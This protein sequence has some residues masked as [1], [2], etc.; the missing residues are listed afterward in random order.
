MSNTKIYFSEIFNVPHSDLEEYGAF[1]I[2]LV[3]DTPAFIDPFLIFANPEFEEWHKAII[4]YLLF[5]KEFSIRNGETELNA[6]IYKHY[7]KFWEVKQIWLW[8]SVA[9]NNG[10]WLGIKFA[11]SLH[12][13]LNRLFSNFWGEQITKSAHLEK[14]CLIDDGVGVDKLSDFT[15]NIIKSFLIDYT[16][17]FSQE[18]IS[19]EFLKEFRI[20]K[21]RFNYSSWIWEDTK[22]ILPYIKIKG[23]DQFVLLTPK[24]ILS[25]N[26]VTWISKNDFLERD[27]TIINSI[28]NEE[29]RSKVNIYFEQ[30]LLQ[31][32]TKTWVEKDYSQ[33][34]RSIALL[35]T[36]YEFPQILDYYIRY[37]ENNSQEALV[38]NQEVV[39]EMQ[40][41]NQDVEVMK[42]S[43]GEF[44]TTS[45]VM[46]DDCLSRIHFFKQKMES[47]SNVLFQ[48]GKN[49]KEKQM[50]L[51]FKMS[52][53][54][55][56]FDYNSEV[57][58]GR[59]PIDFLISYGSGEKMGIE[60]KLASNSK[61]KS[62]LL[63]QSDVYSEDSNLKLVVKV[64]FCFSDDEI[65]KI[66]EVLK[67][68]WVT[69]D[70]YN[71]FIID[72]RKK[73]SASNV[74][75]A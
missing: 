71:Y 50:Q 57:N 75:T 66:K 24:N 3:C 70:N 5:L 59:W 64:I 10:Q 67:S 68:I 20:T 45:L 60:F 25:K 11:K 9:S 33:R 54:G 31:K 47:N 42:S 23:K 58:N 37:K 21:W 44:T 26:A 1:D 6:W 61:L 63:H 32:K 49:L 29:L 40:K 39:L 16:V 34:S 62:N 69:E 56:L 28:D 74:I 48:D 2:S 53:Y 72:C 55:S 15:A 18:K 22:T 43:L 35:K 12:L 27:T 30:Q 8:Y 19:P 14:L 17:K 4:D 52:T 13:N 38:Y 36:T 46:L 51:F 65:V 7:Y 73:V 41:I